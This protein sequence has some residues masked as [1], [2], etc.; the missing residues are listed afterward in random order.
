MDQPKKKPENQ[1]QARKNPSRKASLRGFNTDLL[2]KP[3]PFANYV[4]TLVQNLSQV[5]PRFFLNQNGRDD[6]PHILN[7]NTRCQIL[8]CGPQ[9]ETIILLVIADAEFLPDRIRHF[10][11]HNAY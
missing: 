7:G 6:D 2:L 9:L 4:R 11:A 10:P 3:E 5:S 8:H 1:G